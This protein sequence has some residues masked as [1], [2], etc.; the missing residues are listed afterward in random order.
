MMWPLF[1]VAICAC[2][3]HDIQTAPKLV[4]LG[5]KA[6]IGLSEWTPCEQCQVLEVGILWLEF[7][8][9]HDSDL[10][11][12]F[13]KKMG[14]KKELCAN[15]SM[16]DPHRKDWFWMQKPWTTC[17]QCQFAIFGL[18]ENS[19]EPP[20]ERLQYYTKSADSLKELCRD[21]FTREYFPDF[22][23]LI[24]GKESEIVKVAFDC[25]GLKFKDDKVQTNCRALL[26]LKNC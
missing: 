17:E 14:K 9:H 4:A 12:T 10:V 19:Y 23:P 13:V 25:S 24:D 21:I 8:T 26:K 2:L 1:L 6:N 5:N 7:Y 11:L 20:Y 22:C 3:I 16:C 15:F 18:I